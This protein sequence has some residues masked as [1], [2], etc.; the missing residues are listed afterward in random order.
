MKS[1]GVPSSPAPGFRGRPQPSSGDPAPS[2]TN[3][4]VIRQLREAAKVIDIDHLIVGDAKAGAQKVGHHPFRA[5][6]LL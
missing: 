2:A 5:A 1:F 4:Q 3:I 6:G